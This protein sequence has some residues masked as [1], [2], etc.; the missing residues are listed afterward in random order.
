MPVNDNHFQFLCDEK[1]LVDCGVINHTV[2]SEESFILM[3][4]LSLLY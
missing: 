2:H 4:V 3:K 1:F